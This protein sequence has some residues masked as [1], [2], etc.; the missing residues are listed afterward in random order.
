MPYKAKGKCVYKADTGKKVGCTKGS[1]KKYLAALHANVP[2]A[3]NEEIEE[4]MK[5]KLSEIA[6]KILENHGQNKIMLNGKEVDASSL[7][8]D[9]VDVND[10]PDFS[11]AYI[12]AGNYVDGTPL[13]DEE[14]AQLEDENYGL[15]NDLAHG[16]LSE[17]GYDWRDDP[18]MSRAWEKSDV[19]QDEFERHK[20]FAKQRPV[21]MSFKG[22]TFFNVPSGKDTLA[23]EVGLRK[24]QSGKWGHKHALSGDTAQDKE[25]LNRAEQE[26]G[27]GRYWEPNR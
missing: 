5:I 16:N 10:Y 24:L 27:K 2:D 8:V 21:R 19:S 14:I 1:V 23:Y 7:V 18:A 22:I 9:N 17:G 25:I 13:T 4:P 6:K 3:K 20:G 15:A 11:D 26:F 12:S